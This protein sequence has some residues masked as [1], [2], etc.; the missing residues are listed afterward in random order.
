MELEL[1]VK[2]AAV[3]G[4]NRGIDAAIAAEL[5]SE[6]MD[7]CLVARD[8]DKLCEVAESLRKT[9]NVRVRVFAADPRDPPRRRKPLRRQSVISTVSIGW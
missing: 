8:S 6:G 5:A 2:V 4:S 3:R 1:N 7:L 9:A